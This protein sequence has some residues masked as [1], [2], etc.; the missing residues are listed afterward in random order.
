MAKDGAAGSDDNSLS[1]SLSA[2]MHGRS[3]GMK[4]REEKRSR[5]ESQLVYVMF[6]C[7][8]LVSS[9]CTSIQQCVKRKKNILD[10]KL[11]LGQRDLCWMS[12]E[13]SERMNVQNHKAAADRV[14]LAGPCCVC[15]VRRLQPVKT[16]FRKSLS[17]RTMICCRFWKIL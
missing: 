3:R 5:S 17:N 11:L 16:M 8:L 6:G 15:T 10:L 12:D 9:A 7:R 2:Y 14:R 13:T 1:L 4:R